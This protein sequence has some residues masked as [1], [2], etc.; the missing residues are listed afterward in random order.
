M[1]KPAARAGDHVTGL[2]IHV[3]IVSS[4]G[5][6]LPKTVAL[7]FDGPIVED[8]SDTVFIDSKGAATVGSVA[9]NT[10][11][12]LPLEGPFQKQPS[13]RGRISSGSNTIFFEGK[14]AAGNLDPATCCNDP[15]DEETG[16]VVVLG[17]TT[18]FLD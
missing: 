8:V 12:H 6:P 13:N 2:D 1:T 14:A 17:E 15:A 9:I 16:N 7:P 18:V 4:P 5:G 11:G 3:Q 10:P